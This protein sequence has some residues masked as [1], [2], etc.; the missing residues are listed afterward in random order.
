MPDYSVDA[1]PIVLEPLILRPITTVRITIRYI[2]DDPK[3]DANGSTN[4]G[5]NDGQQDSRQG[6]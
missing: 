3:R 1:K 6:E 5:A 4:D 2:D